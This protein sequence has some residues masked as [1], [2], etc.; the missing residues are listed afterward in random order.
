MNHIIPEWPAPAH[1]GA[2]TTTRIG[3]ESHSPYDSNNMALHVGDNPEYVRA[4]RA[5]LI[6]ELNLPSEPEWL[7]QQHTN[8]CVVVEKDDSR[9]ADAAVTRDA[10]RPLAVMTADCLPI[11]LCDR[12][13]TEIAT[14]H[15]GWRGLADGVIEN[16]LKKMNNQPAALIA[17]I[18][19]S[20]CG[21][22]YEVGEDVMAAFARAYPNMRKGFNQQGGRWYADLPLLAK[23]IMSE[24]GLNAVYTSGACT[25]EDDKHFYS[26]RR[27]GETGRMATLIWFKQD[28]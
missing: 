27:D 5:N 13:G 3:G 7:N 25:K 12:K 26:Y 2:L 15:A 9:T 11:L 6:Q 24:Q 19:P 18:G 14:I 17:W 1:I 4:N 28:K 21:V 8:D 10:K 22:C 16:T 23:L 20:I